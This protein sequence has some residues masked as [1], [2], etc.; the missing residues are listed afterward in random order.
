[1]GGVTVI[2]ENASWLNCDHLEIE[3]TYTP[4]ERPDIKNYTE[5]RD[6]EFDI[7]DV[8]AYI[9]PID[10]WGVHTPVPFAY[11]SDLKVEIERIVVEKI[12]EG[13]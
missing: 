2:V 6:P 8:N 7:D 4:G 10:G 9:E 11:Y 12:K 13:I 5:G 3:G 1:M